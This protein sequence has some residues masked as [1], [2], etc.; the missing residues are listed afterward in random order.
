MLDKELEN[1]QNNSSFKK[2]VKQRNILRFMMFIQFSCLILILI[3]IASVLYIYTVD[4]TITFNISLSLTGL[5]AILVFVLISKPIGKIKKMFKYSYFDIVML[6]IIKKVN[7]TWKYSLNNNFLE[8]FRDFIV[9]N[10]YAINTNRFFIEKSIDGKV[11]ENTNI[12]IHQVELL[13]VTGFS[14]HTKINKLFNGIFAITD[15]NI[16]PYINV[17]IEGNNEL[18]QIDKILDNITIRNLVESFYKNTSL[19]FNLVITNGKIFFRIFSGNKFNEHI[20]KK[21]I[22][23]NILTDY[24]STLKF[25]QE[26]S[27]EIIKQIDNYN[28]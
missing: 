3:C 12:Q 24:Y 8:I 4:S 10:S 21:L 27:Y 28:V 14:Q 15:A 22:D 13:N 18:I 1:I 9:S 20:F 5:L 6:P 19:D 11:D 23:K 25:I 16:N 26:I 17:S 2:L 7:T